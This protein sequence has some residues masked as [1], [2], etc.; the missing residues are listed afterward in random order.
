VAFPKGFFYEEV[1]TKSF[2]Q[3]KRLPVEDTLASL[4]AVAFGR[5]DAALGEAAV[6]RTLIN[7]NFI[8]GLQISGEV[9]IGD[10]DLMNLRIGVR[11]DWPLLQSALMKAM[12]AIA[13]QEMNQI[14]QKWIVTGLDS[15]AA[16][17]TAVTLSYGRLI[18]YGIAVFLALSLLAWI[19]I[20][21]VKKENIAVSFGSR[22]FRGLVLAGL[23][24]FIIIVCL[25]GWFTL[26]KNK[27]NILEDIA[28]TSRKV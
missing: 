7:K 15:E 20:K 14:Q 21:T 22:W 2:P 10:P 16:P 13:P 5:A 28:E 6:V 18:V 19:L 11:N 1:L 24:I 4:K 17:Q 3:I 23:S 9:N 26:E 8:S 25:L 12:A 27:E